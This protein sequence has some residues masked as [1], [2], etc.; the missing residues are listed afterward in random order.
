M[1]MGMQMSQSPGGGQ[2]AAFKQ[3]PQHFA[4]K[5]KGL[6]FTVK[7]DDIVNFFSGHKIIDDSIKIGQM[8]DG[9]LTGE[10]VVRFNDSNDCATAHQRLDQKHIGSRWI[11][12]IKIAN[13]EY[14]GFER[15][16][17][18]KY[19]GG[20]NYYGGG[21]YDGGYGGGR[22]GRGGRGRGRGR[23]GY[24]SGYGGGAAS[25]SNNSDRGYG[26]GRGGGGNTV[27]LSDFVNAE[28]RFQALKMRGLPFSATTKDIREFF[29]DFRVAERDITIDLNNGRPTGYALVFFESDTEAQRA[30]DTM[31][32]K[33]LGSRYVD[34]SFPELR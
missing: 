1:N 26:G 25:Y 11:K 21:G 5:M 8:S 12:L 30:K 22:G 28:N 14:D 3:E 19:E 34:L 9:K 33:Y 23:G 27:R 13:Q 32:K 31:N 20:G 29:Q 4:I 6:P 15:E 2:A 17:V 10:A 7:R 24:D 16:Q 18:S